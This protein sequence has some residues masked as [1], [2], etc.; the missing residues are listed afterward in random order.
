[1]AE[2]ALDEAVVEL[3]VGAA[4]HVGG[5]IGEKAAADLVKAGGGGGHERALGSTPT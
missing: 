3:L 1:M 5:C 2:L 4:G